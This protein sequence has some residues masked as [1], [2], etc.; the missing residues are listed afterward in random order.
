MQGMYK[1]LRCQRLYYCSS[2][3]EHIAQCEYFKKC[4]LIK[5]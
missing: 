3:N 2:K 5:L 4:V 1:R